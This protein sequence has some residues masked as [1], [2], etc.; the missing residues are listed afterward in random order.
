[1]RRTL[2]SPSHSPS[3]RSSAAGSAAATATPQLLV[4]VSASG[5]LC[6]PHICHWGG[7]ITTTTISAD[8]R[9]S[10]RITAAERLALTRA[11]AQLHPASLPKFAGTCPIAYDGQ[12]LTYRFRDKPVVRSCTYDLRH[13]KAV[14]LVDR[15]I[16]SLPS[17]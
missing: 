10:R 17:R 16:A 15:L 8:G 4:T 2:L 1:M 12:E 14:Q 9:R 11:I 7:R 5:G 3:W 13:V 6:P